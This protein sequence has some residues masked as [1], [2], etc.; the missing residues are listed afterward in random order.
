M[1]KLKITVEDSET[2]ESWPM[3]FECDNFSISE[4]QGF[5]KVFDSGFRKSGPGIRS[6]GQYRLTLR[7]WRG[8]P[9]FDDFVSEEVVGAVVGQ[10]GVRKVKT[11]RGEFVQPVVPPI[12]IGVGDGE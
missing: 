5:Q 1:K 8:C 12:F 7:A 3:E 10:V 6:N 11:D 9:E 2:G 4:E